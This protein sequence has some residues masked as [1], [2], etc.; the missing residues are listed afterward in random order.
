ME[1]HSPQFPSS[2]SPPDAM[3]QPSGQ[4]QSSD[5]EVV[6]NVEYPDSAS[7]PGQ[8]SVD[9]VQNTF[10]FSSSQQGVIRAYSSGD[11]RLASLA[12]FR[13]RT[14]SDSATFPDMMTLVHY[15]GAIDTSAV[16][17]EFSH[18][19]HLPQITIPDTEQTNSQWDL[20]FPRPPAALSPLLSPY[21]PYLSWSDTSSARSVSPS[22]SRLPSPSL[23]PPDSFSGTYTGGSPDPYAPSRS[24]S[25][26]ESSSRD[27]EPTV[28]GR[29][30]L[31]AKHRKP[32]HFQ[33]SAGPSDSGA[34][35]I[36][37]RIDTLSLNGGEG[38]TRHSYS[39]D[40]PAIY[41]QYPISRYPT[42]QAHGMQLDSPWAV[43]GLSPGP[44][45]QPQFLSPGGFLPVPQPD[46]TSSSSSSPS[47]NRRIPRSS[48]NFVD[49]EGG[50]NGASLYPGHSHRTPAFEH[51]HSP[52]IPQ[53]SGDS[54]QLQTALNFVD[55]EERLNVSSL[56]SGPSRSNP[57]FE[58]PHSPSI[59]HGEG[60]NGQLQTRLSYHS[61]GLSAARADGNT[62]DWKQDLP[63]LGGSPSTDLLIDRHHDA[64]APR[65]ERLSADLGTPLVPPEAQSNQ[66]ALNQPRPVATEA[67]R[68]ASRKRRRDPNKRGQYVCEVENCNADF[69]AK[70]N[71]Q[72]HI[73]S[74]FSNKKYKC[75]DCGHL[76]V[77]QYCQTR[78]ASRC[79][80][81]FRRKTI[82][83][84]KRTPL[85]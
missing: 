71:L 2:F 33:S 55:F 73:N 17:D 61:A 21:S 51:P 54:G 32:R 57:A 72:N 27:G 40:S 41:F 43:D 52:S 49:F 79:P 38:A 45:F 81:L 24:H 56:Y 12:A 67:T 8:E 22:P 14:Q 30:P 42:S 62:T 16:D 5:H 1:D 60:D 75:H 70:H 44:G 46:T 83:R 69:T 4:A 37:I 18:P 28:R 63:N 78:H 59:P 74:H 48:G 35:D 39:N 11:Q 58:H 68:T 7:C 25:T 77:T 9:S 31:R 76:F 20:R 53:G 26:Y 13:R 10:Q 50:L 47:P 3:T 64:W 84:K 29:S 19:S 80:A 66:N 6:F 65:A 15:D 36:H 82:M 34:D 23:L 85:N